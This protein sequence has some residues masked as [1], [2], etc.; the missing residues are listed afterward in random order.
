MKRI[1]SIFLMAF[2]AFSVLQAAEVTFDFSTAEGINAMGYTVPEQSAGTNLVQ[3]GP[4]TVSGVTLSATDGAT[5]TRIWNS[6]GSFSLRIYVDGTITLSVAEGSITGVTVNAANSANFDLLAD[7]GEYSVSGIV[8]TW[9]G[10]ASSVTFTHVAP[11]TLK[12]QALLSPPAAM[13]LLTLTLRIPSTPISPNSTRFI[14]LP[15]WRTALLSS[16]QVTFM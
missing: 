11:R 8:G 4:K 3:A 10:N 15:H 14:I 1:F 5:P 16:S 6:Q 2:W 7:V 12:W 13:I 9:T